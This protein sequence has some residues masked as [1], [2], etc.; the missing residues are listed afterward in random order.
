MLYSEFILYLF[1]I[2][3]WRN[4]ADMIILSLQMRKFTLKRGI[5][6]LSILWLWHHFI[7]HLTWWNPTLFCQQSWCH[8]GYFR[9]FGSDFH[10]LKWAVYR[11]GTAC[12]GLFVL[13][14]FLSKVPH[15]K[16]SKR[17]SDLS[18]ATQLGPDSQPEKE[19]VCFKIIYHVLDTMA[20]ALDVLEKQLFLI[21][22]GFLLLKCLTSAAPT[23][24]TKRWSQSPTRPKTIFFVPDIDYICLSIPGISLSDTRQHVFSSMEM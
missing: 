12:C 16:L 10:G 2:T 21:C 14:C 18:K 11:G 19:D 4:K 1:F 23:L 8:S 24:M 17:L 3:W 13:W 5:L 6:F 15:R 22:S 7:I 20:I 9:Q